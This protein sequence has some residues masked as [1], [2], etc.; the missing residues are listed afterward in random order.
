MFAKLCINFWDRAL[1]FVI[2]ECMVSELRKCYFSWHMAWGICNWVERSCPGMPTIWRY[3]YI[4]HRSAPQ[5]TITKFSKWWASELE[6]MT[7][8]LPSYTFYF[9][10]RLKTGDEMVSGDTLLLVV[11]AIYTIMAQSLNFRW[12][13]TN[14]I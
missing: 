10:V 11:K 12:V 1:L 6:S 8:A 7:T 4:Y 5:A 2:L 3:I 14:D 13:L 9:G